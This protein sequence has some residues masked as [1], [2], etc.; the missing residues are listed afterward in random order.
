MKRIAVLFVLVFC[1]GATNAQQ[2]PSDELR[3][4]AVAAQSSVSSSAEAR[5][6]ARPE[7]GFG[8]SSGLE[9]PGI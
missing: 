7:V 1:S 4:D 9:N 8:G 6:K 2:S 5:M 3:S